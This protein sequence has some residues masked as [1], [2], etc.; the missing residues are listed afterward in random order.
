MSESTDASENQLLIEAL[1]ESEE[2]FRSAFQHAAIGMALVALDGRWLQINRS[3]SEI[4][5]YS[6]QEL[7]ATNFQS[8]THPA[9]LDLDLEYVRR[10][11]GGEIRTYQMTKRYFHRDGHVVWALLSVS[12]VRGKLRDPLYF[13]SQIQDI[14]EQK[15]A[16]EA[17]LQS[18]ARF[19]QLVTQAVDG[20]FVHDRRGKI[21]DA[22]PQACQSL[23][24]TR[25]ELTALN[26]ADIEVGCPPDVL[27]EGWRSLQPGESR[28]ITGRHRR[29]DGTLFPVE[30]RIGLVET[31]GTELVMGLARDVSERFRAEAIERDRREVLEL[32]AKGFSIDQC[33]ERLAAMVEQRIPGTVAAFLTLRDGEFRLLGPS[34][35]ETLSATIQLKPLTVSAELC[36]NVLHEHRP[37]RHD[38]RNETG[39]PAFREA[40]LACGLAGA[41]A[42]RIDGFDGNPLGVFAVFMPEPADP[43]DWQSGLCD[44]ATNLAAM[45]IERHQISDNLAQRAYRDPLTGSGNRFFFNLRLVDA[46]DAAN[47]GGEPGGLLLLDLDR[48]KDV[49]DRLGHDVGDE[50]LQQFAERVRG[51]LRDGDAFARLGGDE[52]AILLPGTRTRADMAI[53]TAKLAAELR[54]PFHLKAGLIPVTTSMG[55]SLYPQDGD[56][57]QSVMKAADRALYRVKENGRDGADLGEG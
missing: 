18:E 4:L 1:R 8:I 30:V 53:V 19:R 51:V 46:I 50:L 16:D 13:I 34:L 12:L 27:A 49:N 57:P 29:K 31:G 38:F 48:F 39:W 6:E 15:A 11:V 14:S 37:M 22:N 17:I 41:W 35:P 2:R 55:G 23:Q 33:I 20:V 32:V 5:G 3:L 28:T 52:F 10:L 43:F 42:F 25:E 54:K 36:D 26:I 44:T 40:A 7:L 9:D 21:L 45:T 56:S 47:G 24:Y